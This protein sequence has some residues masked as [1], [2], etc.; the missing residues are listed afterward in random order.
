LAVKHL[1]KLAIYTG[2]IPVK[3]KAKTTA[4][5]SVQREAEELTQYWHCLL[6]N[7]SL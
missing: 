6:C 3:P 2:N 5:R 7:Y 4:I 1:N